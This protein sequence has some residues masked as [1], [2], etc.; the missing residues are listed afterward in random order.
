MV[1]AAGLTALGSLGCDSGA[2]GVDACRDIED[3]RCEAALPCG[4]VIDVAAC[5]RFYRDH[6]LHGLASASSPSADQLNACTDT[7]T[8]AGE[9]RSEGHTELADCPTPPSSSTELTLVCDVVQ[10]PQATKECDFLNDPADPSS[11]S[12]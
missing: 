5:K 10:E 7:I 11:E 12:E 1:L 4:I 6:C 9:C 2:V 8:L 3:A